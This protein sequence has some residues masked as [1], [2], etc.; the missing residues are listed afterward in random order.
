MARVTREVRCRARAHMG[1]AQ[2]SCDVCKSAR[3]ARFIDTTEQKPALRGPRRPKTTRAGCASAPEQTRNEPGPPTARKSSGES[4]QSNKK[5]RKEKVR[6][7]PL[8]TGHLS[9]T[10]GLSRS[11][12][13]RERPE[14]N[15]HRTRSTSPDGIDGRV[16]LTRSTF[17]CGSDK[18]QERSGR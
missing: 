4:K 10:A 8:P 15:V 17:R 2:R 1:T 12:V 3:R 18:S 5:M 11:E 7:Q 16:A 6:K 9:T 13:G 14:E